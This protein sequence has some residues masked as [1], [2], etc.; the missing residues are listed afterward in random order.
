MNLRDIYLSYWVTSLYCFYWVLH[1]HSEHKKEFP[2]ESL[3]WI[4]V[5]AVVFSQKTL[6]SSQRVSVVNSFK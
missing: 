4:F 3:I 6:K 1:Q 2:Q 5:C